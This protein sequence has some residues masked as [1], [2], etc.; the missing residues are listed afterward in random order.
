MNVDLENSFLG[1]RGR[2][3]IFRIIFLG[4]FIQNT[5]VLFEWFN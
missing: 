4:Y 1:P 2:Q 3:F 5:F